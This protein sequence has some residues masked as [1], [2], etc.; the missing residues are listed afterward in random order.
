M[1]ATVFDT[2]ATIGTW[3]GGLCLGVF[4]GAL[5]GLFGAGG[6]FIL[7]PALNIFLGLPYNIAVGTST[8]QIL[9]A[10]TLAL[11]HH[12]DRRLFGV[13]VA[14]LAG[15]G[16]LPGTFLGVR[17][18]NRLRDMGALCI[19]G[20]LIPAQE[21]YFTAFFC[22]FLSLIAGWL[23]FD[24][25]YLRRHQKDERN[26]KGY[27]SGIRIP[28]LFAFRTLPHGSFSAPVLVLLGGGIG[29]LGGLLGIG[30]GVIM[31]PVLFYLV[32]QETKYATLTSTMLVFATALFSSVQ[33]GLHGNINWTLVAVLI[34]GA[35]I[36][37][38]L[39]AAIQRRLTG[40]SIR[41]YFAFVVLAAAGM[42]VWKLV[43]VLTHSPVPV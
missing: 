4:A 42:V 21:F 32:G 14:L 27:L 13:R 1:L 28:P 19:N 5:T 20:R 18:V 36:G 7:T 11:H 39:G 41:R 3:A 17:V 24:T 38:R 25:F 2:S 15:I 16:I 12:L 23:L 40:L 22:A 43:I 6:G 35:F 33:H 26:H 9:G 37:T 34:A 30:G 31:M 29:F 10:S 8:C